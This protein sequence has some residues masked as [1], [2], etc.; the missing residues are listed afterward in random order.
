M[1]LRFFQRPTP[2]IFLPEIL[3]VTLRS[4]THRGLFSSLL[5]ACVR[6]CRLRVS[7]RCGAARHGGGLRSTEFRMWL[8]LDSQFCVRW[9]NSKYKSLRAHLLATRATVSGPRLART[10][11]SNASCSLD[12]DTFFAY[13][14][15][16]Y[17]QTRNGS[18]WDVI[19]RIHRTERCSLSLSLFLSV[20]T[21]SPRR[22]K[23]ATS[24]TC[25]RFEMDIL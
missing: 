13:S 24:D 4:R 17:T 11:P 6:P 15:L 16:V 10:F 21:D 25:T 20:F 5:P 3:F 1:S 22:F 2:A 23:E 18:A 12:P 9:L 8:D 19:I 14:L 7:V